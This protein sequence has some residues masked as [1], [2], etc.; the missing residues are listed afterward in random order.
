MVK[1]RKEDPVARNWYRSDRFVEE[2]GRWFF[3]TREGTV[4]GPFES[5]LEATCR[6]ETYINVT[7]SGIVSNNSGLA[8]SA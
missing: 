1:K 4:E 7:N 6:L 2:R 3:Y 8:L 5:K